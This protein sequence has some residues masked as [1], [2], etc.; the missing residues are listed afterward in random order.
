MAS[1]PSPLIARS[2]ALCWLLIAQPV[3]AQPQGSDLFSTSG[4]YDRFAVGNAHRWYDNHS[5]EAKEQ[6][7]HCLS[8]LDEA[9]AYQERAFALYAQAKQ[10]G[11]ASAQVT[12]LRKQGME[13]ITLRETKIRA[14]IDC[15]NHA[16]RHTGPPS[17]Q[18]A[19]GG[20]GTSGDRVQAQ[21]P[22]SHGPDNRGNKGIKRVPTQR[23]APQGE[24]QPSTF[25]TAVDDCFAT[26]VS[27]YRGPDWARYN[28]ETPRQ[29]RGGPGRQP[30]EMLGV[31]AD[32]ALD[33]DE[34]V[35]GAWQDRELMRDYLIGWLMH[36]LTNRKVVPKED[37]RIPYR[38]FM[39]ARGPA[40][41]K[42]RKRITKRF[43]EFGY[44][45]RSYPLPPFWDHE[46]AG[47]PSPSQ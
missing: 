28:R 4:G 5:T 15:F 20:D 40:D 12:A 31:A 46:A 39:E 43:E 30:F 2:A 42:N 44:G 36:C 37:P 11:L 7:R 8:L 47:P 29:Q 25:Q 14:F 27:N 22:P 18:F 6:S 21:S 10:P 1:L 41:W 13:Q 32:Q 45:Y 34:A 33:L 35:Y 24:S 3:Q 16:M 19:S 17:D 38:R 9:N 23:P 26:S